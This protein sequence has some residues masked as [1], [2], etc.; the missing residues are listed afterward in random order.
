M[1]NP[2]NFFGW[3]MPENTSLVTDLPADFEVFGQAVDTDFQDLLGGTT[4]QVLS[5]TSGTDLDFTWVDPTAGDI[6]GVTAGTGISGGG[7]SGDVTVT[8]SMATAFTTSGDLIQAT[9]SGTFARLGTG[10]N[11]QYLTT[12]GTTNSWGTI[13]AGGMTLLSTT[14]LS[15]ATT[16][17]TSISQDYLHLQ[18][19]IQSIFLSSSD[20]CI[21]K[22]NTSQTPSL[23]GQNL[24]TNWDK[25]S[26]EFIPSA[27]SSITM[28]IY[29]IYNY[30]STTGNKGVLGVSRGTS[31]NPN[32]F[33]GQINTNT[34][35][36]AINFSA[37]GAVTY[38][39]GTVRLYG[40]K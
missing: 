28:V 23:A 33:F 2:T 11:G 19:V 1:T 18:M 8:N 21:I 12:D 38:T 10:T 30:S 7:T 29:N 39:G 9:G 34:A 14:T 32:L 17:I 27:N 16:N 13:S 35:I 22:F 37:G 40:V 24:T 15:G 3:Q 26:G 25:T 6:T 4:G 5:K 20:D 31:S 36:S